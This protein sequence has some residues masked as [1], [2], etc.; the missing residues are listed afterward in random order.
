[1]RASLGTKT[2]SGL[3]SL[4]DLNRQEI[5]FVSLAALAP[6]LQ[7][8]VGDHLT[9]PWA[10]WYGVIAVKT[11]EQTDEALHESSRFMDHTGPV[12]EI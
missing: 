8:P 12:S 1:M 3:L 9:N 6:F 4:L 7:L 11:H 5:G 10:T 2:L